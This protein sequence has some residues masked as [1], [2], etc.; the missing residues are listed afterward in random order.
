MN[1]G[2]SRVRH[3]VEAAL[4]ALNIDDELDRLVNPRHTDHD[5]HAYLPNRVVDAVARARSEL[6]SALQAFDEGNPGH[7]PPIS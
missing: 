2:L 1:A 7:E 6:E 3:H 5:R 4:A